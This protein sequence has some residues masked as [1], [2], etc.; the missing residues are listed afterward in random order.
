METNI[1][2][3][4]LLKNFV[5]NNHYLTRYQRFIQQAQVRK[6]E[7]N[8]R[9]ET[10]HIVP[11]SLGGSDEPTNLIDLT[12]REHYIAHWMLWKALPSSSSM[13]FAFL[14]M[15]QKNYKRDNESEKVYRKIRHSRMYA[16][17]KE[18]AYLSH[19][20]DHKGKVYAR[21]DMGNVVK[22]TSDVF[23]EDD[24]LSFHTKGMTAAVNIV[25]GERLW[26]TTDEYRSNGDLKH[27]RSREYAGDLF[28]SPWSNSNRIYILDGEEVRLSYQ[29]FLSLR[30]QGREVKA[31]AYFSE[32]TKNRMKN[33]V[34][35]QDA[36]GKWL[37]ISKEEFDS[38]RRMYRTSTEESV[39]AVNIK[40]GEQRL[41]S[42]EIYDA[43]DE[44][45]GQTKGL[46]TVYDT[47]TKRYTQVTREQAKDSRY[48]GPNKGKVNAIHKTTGVRKQIPKA[49]FD[50]AVWHPLGNKSMSFMCVSKKNGKEKRIYTFE[51]KNVGDQYTVVDENRFEKLKKMPSIW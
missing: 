18:Q 28:V 13:R 12:L 19:S 50:K 27:P 48:H 46:T 16:K 36:S 38:N 39:L 40:T 43:S 5:P 23:K 44:W 21:D 1:V 31:K 47:V 49:E 9:T 8:T 17:L 33:S 42:K 24:R 7:P 22:V 6:L 11:R 37:V 32:E 3:F 29:E 15:C 25:T 41:I 30:K 14:A 2:E 51:W 4:S 45:V 34:R 26:V 35:V 20:N 10:H